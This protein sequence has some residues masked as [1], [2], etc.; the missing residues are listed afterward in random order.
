MVFTLLDI[1]M[2][3]EMSMGKANSPFSPLELDLMECGFY[4]CCMNQQMFSGCK[5]LTS[6]QHEQQLLTFF[7]YNSSF[8]FAR[9]ALLQ[10][11][12]SGL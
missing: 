6:V 12:N 10:H 5:A 11:R 7:V 2:W 4:D 3:D 1:E 9:Y 8:C